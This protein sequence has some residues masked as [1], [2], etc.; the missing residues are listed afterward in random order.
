M[1]QIQANEVAQWA[2]EHASAQPVVLDVREAWEVQH[3][4]ISPPA[5]AQLMHISMGTVPLRL[6][7][8]DKNKPIACLCHHGGRSMQVAMFLEGNGFAQVA[9]IV[10]GIDAWS[11]SVD[12]SVPRY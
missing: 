11:L 12:A 3:A 6:N 10:G 2:Q 8:L 4:S 9:N 7:D 1:Q 5:G